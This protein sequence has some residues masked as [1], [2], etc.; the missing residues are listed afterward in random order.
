[1]TKDAYFEMCEML[2][3][4]PTESEIPVEISDF[5]EL[6]QQCFIIYRMLS[7]NWDSMGG[8]YMGKDYSLV[9]DLFRV[10]NITESE[11]IVLCL[12]FL[13]QM[14]DVRQQLIATKLKA[15]SPQP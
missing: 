5:P 2:G 4:E 8:G 12:N 7:D 1:M 6:V 13:Q 3:E 14:D 15:K 10:Y 11:E 9:F